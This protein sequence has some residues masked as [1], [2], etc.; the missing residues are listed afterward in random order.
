M[1]KTIY[2]MMSLLLLTMGSCK[3]Y[4]DQVPDDVITVDDIFKSRANTERFLANIYHSLPNEL[5]Q[6]YT[7]TDNSGT[8]TASS[9]EAKYNW[10]FNYSNNMNKSTWSNTDGAVADLWNGYYVAIRNATYFIKNIDSA[11]PVEVPAAVRSTYKAEAKA[12]RALYYFYLIRMYGPVPILGDDLLD[13]NAPIADLRLPR[14]PVDQGIDFVVSELDAAYADL[15]YTPN[16]DQYGRITKGVCKAYKVEA[17]M[18]KASPLFNGNISYAGLT[19][20]DGTKLFSQT[21]DVAKWATAA[22]AAKAFIDEFVPTYYALYKETDADPFIAAYKSCKNVMLQD[23]NKEWIFARSNSGNY[24]QYDRT[25]KHIGAASSASGIQG[26]GAIGATQKIVDA[27]FMANGRSIDDAQSGY[28]ASGFSSFKAPFDIAERSTYNQWTNREPRFYVGITYTNS[29]WLNQVSGSAAL[30][31]DFTLNGNS[32]RSQ[33][34]SDVS[35]TGYGI[36]KNVAANGNG[37]GALMLRLANIYLDYA[38]ALNESQPGNVAILTYLNLIRERAG[39]PQYGAGANALPVP[40]SQ[41]EMQ[42]AIRKERQIELAFE[43]VRY[44][45]T[46]RWKIAE[47]TDAGAVYGLD[48][49]K[50]GTE[51]YN[52]TL[53]ETRVFNKVR[54]YL[55]PIP[56]AEVLKNNNM[57]QNLGW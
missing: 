36:R 35:P 26:G 16:L 48:M 19:N 12:L 34:T 23:W 47:T 37:R 55:Y 38:E 32:G 4:L 30:I 6:R 33:S 53:I 54:D 51:F 28:N 39:V 56:N 42:T 52:K 9:D 29:Y 8:W 15:P 57:V 20:A 13:I 27:Y 24:L 21:N 17:L 1:K 2:I 44:F 40:A 22:A 41:L 49:T 14:T 11:N 50:S 25:P 7:S 46:R 45:D 31:T 3:K 10:D 18:L 5:A 43:N